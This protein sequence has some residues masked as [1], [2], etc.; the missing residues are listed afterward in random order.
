MLPLNLFLNYHQHEFHYP[1][2]L[3]EGFGSAFLTVVFQHLVE[4]LA[5]TIKRNANQN[6]KGVS[7]HTSQS[8]NH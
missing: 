8:D 1:C 7:L 6:N 2:K 5:Q 4:C 3:H